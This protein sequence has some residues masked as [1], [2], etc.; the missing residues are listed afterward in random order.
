MGAWLLDNREVLSMPVSSDWCSHLLLDF[1]AHGEAAHG[2]RTAWAGHR[3]GRHAAFSGRFFLHALAS[4]EGARSI[5]ATASAVLPLFRLIVSGSFFRK[6]AVAD[7]FWLGAV[8]AVQNSVVLTLS[9][10]LCRAGPY[11]AMDFVRGLYAWAAQ[12]G[13][14]EDQLVSEELWDAMHVRQA[15]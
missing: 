10:R 7:H 13:R 3:E 9:P 6:A 4:A 2:N 12:A 14:I 15:R 5:E 11:N 1:D 8:A